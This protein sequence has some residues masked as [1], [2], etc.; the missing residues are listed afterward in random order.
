MRMLPVGMEVKGPRP[1]A[2][3]MLDGP[4]AK[5]DYKHTIHAMNDT[6]DPAALIRNALTAHHDGNC[7]A[8]LAGAATN[9]SKALLLPGVKELISKKLRFLTVV[10]DSSDT[11]NTNKLLAEWS[12]R[13]HRGPGDRRATS[14]TLVEHREGLRVVPAH[15][16]ADAYRAYKPMPYDAAAPAL[17]AVLYAVRPQENYFK[18]TDAGKHRKLVY[19]PAQKERILKAYTEIASAKP[20]PR[21]PRFRQQVAADQDEK[22]PAEAKPAAPEK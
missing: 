7:L 2:E 18:V 13:G 22:K 1:G 20:V 6:A 14:S 15:P 12:V 17:A 5:P 16:V 9:F 21:M 11:E 3:P 4:L 8:I 19:D 10:P